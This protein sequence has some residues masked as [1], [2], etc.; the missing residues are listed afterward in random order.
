MRPLKNNW[1]RVFAHFRQGPFLFAFGDPNFN[2]G[3]VRG[4]KGATGERGCSLQGVPSARPFAAARGLYTAVRMGCV[5]TLYGLYM[6]PYGLY[7]LFMD[8]YGL[9]AD[10]MRIYFCFLKVDHLLRGVATP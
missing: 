7:G 4:P 2:R 10:Y 5:W 3:S 8:L 6:A 9:C 1:V